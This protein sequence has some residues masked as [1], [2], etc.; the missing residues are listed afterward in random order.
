MSVPVY[1]LSKVGGRK[2]IRDRG[3]KWDE[4]YRDR[5]SSLKKRFEKQI[6]PDSYHR[7]EGHD[8]TSNSMYYVVVGPS[9][10]RRLGKVFFAGIKKISMEDFMLDPDTKTYSPYG[11]YFFNIKSALLYANE[12]WGVP[13]VKGQP[14]YKKEHIENA[15]IPEHV[16]A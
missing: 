5:S 12:R 4:K 9:M 1:N 8:F 3:I 13:I 7:W 6:G 11:E 14:A 15:D 10:H 2:R 16:K